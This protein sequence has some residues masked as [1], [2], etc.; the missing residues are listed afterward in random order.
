MTAATLTFAFTVDDVA[1]AGWSTP[2]HLRRLYDFLDE[3]Q[4]PATFFVVP[5]AEDGTP[6]SRQSGYAAALAEGLK[7]GHEFA[8]HGITHDR[9]E[10]GIPPPMIM[11]L[12]HEGPARRRPR[13]LPL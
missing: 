3:E 4:I 9:F 5:E 8:Q 6:V 12:P 11:E 7:R 10:V 1:L 2:D 13:A